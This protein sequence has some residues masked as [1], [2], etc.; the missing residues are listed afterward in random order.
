MNKIPTADVSIICANY[1]NGKYLREFIQSVI[2]SSMLPYELIIVDDGSTDDSLAILDEFKDLSFLKVIEFE[3]NKGF[4]SALNKALDLAQGKYVMRADPDDI[5]HPLRIEKQFKMMESDLSID[6][7]GSNFT[8]INADSKD[9][10]FESNFPEQSDEIYRR[11]LSGRHGMAH[12]TICGK[13]SIYKCYRYQELFPGEDYEIFSRMARD[14]IKLVNTQESLYFVRVHPKSSTSNIK[15]SHIRQTFAFRDKI[16]GTS[17]SLFSIYA[18]Y[19]FV[20]CYRGFQMDSNVFKKI[21]YLFVAA[22]FSPNR[23]SNRLRIRLKNK[24]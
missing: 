6:V 22:L 5:F 15:L 1:N 12:G 18:E 11:Y 24:L 10:L 13:S 7:L 3:S 20:K 9:V 17:T 16:F 21:G 8:Y 23:I 14:K 2:D 4:T 19:L